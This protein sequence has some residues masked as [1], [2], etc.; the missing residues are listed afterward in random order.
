MH[1]I[2]DII[3]QRYL[4]TRPLGVRQEA[5]MWEAEH[6]IS[7]R[8][9]T[10]KLV[11]AEAGG[12]NARGRFASEARITAE[13]GHPGIV[14]VYDVGV[15]DGTAFLVLERLR[16]ETLADIIS[17]QGAMQAEDAS[18]VMLQV[19]A[20]LEAAHSVGV[21]HGDL[22]AEGVI[23]RRGHDGQLIVKLLDFGASVRG[24]HAESDAPVSAPRAAVG[25]D[26]RDD[27]QAAGAILYDMLTGRVGVRQGARVQGNGSI[28]PPETAQA[29]VP[30]IPAGLARVVDQAMAMGPGRPIGSAREMASMLSPFAVSE[31][32]PSLAPRDTLMPFLSPEARRSRGMARLERAV[33]GLGEPKEKTSVRP[34]LVLIE[35]AQD[36]APRAMDSAVKRGGSEA[37]RVMPAQDLVS[38]R[39]PRPPRTPEI[40]EPQTHHLRGRG[41][42]GGRWRK[43]TSVAHRRWR[44]S[45]HSIGSR[46]SELSSLQA[47]A[48]NRVMRR[49]WSAGLLAAAGMG[50][51]LLLGHLLH[52]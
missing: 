34:N 5:E 19:L 17:H 14:D 41:E 10:I 13:I 35:G 39:I 28:P 46:T 22:R 49:I 12:A 8:K 30:A 36:G 4:L 52:F 11:S 43:R 3:D 40:A 9:V 45:R 7:G 20:G 16:G 1:R 32:P 38:P 33:L 6:K 44:A 15:A 47:A 27:V 31:K 37:P 18:H 29:L 26:A 23:L 25:F 48:M 42:S 24:A 2:G 51:G 21:A 50:A